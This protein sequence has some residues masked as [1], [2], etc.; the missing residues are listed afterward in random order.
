[1][2]QSRVAVDKQVHDAVEALKK[3]SNLVQDLENTLTNRTKRL[4]EL[5]EEYN[6]YVKL[7]E[8]SQE[9]AAALVK[10]IGSELGNSARRE[11][12]SSLVINIIAGSII[13]VLGVVFAKPINRMIGGLF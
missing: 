12:I 11:R 2:N 3:S 4:T 13:F 10:Q 9:Q 7:S 1:M 5:Q 8:I 6:K